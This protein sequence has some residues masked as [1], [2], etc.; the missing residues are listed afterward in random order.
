ML[1]AAGE[2]GIT[3]GHLNREFTRIVGLTPLSVIRILRIR[4]LL[5]RLGPGVT[6]I[7]YQ[8]AQTRYFSERERDEAVGFVPQ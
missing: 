3:H 8:R 4:A 1:D 2:L 5:A 7:Q 6:P